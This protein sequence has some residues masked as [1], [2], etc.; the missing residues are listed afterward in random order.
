MKVN[1]LTALE[2]RGGASIKKKRGIEK[3][4]PVPVIPKELDISAERGGEESYIQEL[5][6]RLDANKFYS[7]KEER[8]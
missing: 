7:G 5:L 3:T 8:R 6:V 2:E 4:I 1:V